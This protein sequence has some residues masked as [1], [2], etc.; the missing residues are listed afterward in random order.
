MSWSL[1][2][3]PIFLI[4]LISMTLVHIL[5]TPPWKTALYNTFCTELLK[6]KLSDL[7]SLKIEDHLNTSSG[8]LT[9]LIPLSSK[10][11]RQDHSSDLQWPGIWWRSLELLIN[12]FSITF[13]RFVSSKGLVPWFT[14]SISSWSSKISLRMF[15]VQFGSSKTY[16]IN[17][18]FA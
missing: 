7:K 3:A 18:K 5:F 2:Q 12:V 10:L 8:F 15:V 16:H 4:S 14:S 13:S 17:M 9:C 11:D 1:M 6:R